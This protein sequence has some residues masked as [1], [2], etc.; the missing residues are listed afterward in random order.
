MFSTLLAYRGVATGLNDLGTEH[1]STEARQYVSAT[2]HC[3]RRLVQGIAGLMSQATWETR[4][5]AA[6]GSEEPTSVT[7]Q[8]DE[9]DQ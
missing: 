5:S 7:R 2:S 8:C 6:V 9:G 3:V 1:D 4:V